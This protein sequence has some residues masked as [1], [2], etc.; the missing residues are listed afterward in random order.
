MLPVGGA[1]NSVLGEGMEVNLIVAQTAAS[2]KLFF[3]Q[4]TTNEYEI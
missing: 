2:T 1:L 3:T 4:H